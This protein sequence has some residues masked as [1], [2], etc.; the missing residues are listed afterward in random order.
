MAAQRALSTLDDAY[1]KSSGSYKNVPDWMYRDLASDYAKILVASGQISE[2]GVDKIMQ[3]SAKGAV[4]EI[5]NRLTGDTKTTAPEKV[6]TLLHDRIKALNTDLDKQYYN[7]TSGSNIP[8]NSN[9]NTNPLNNNPNAD[10]GNGNKVTQPIQ[11]GKY[12]IKKVK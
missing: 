4:V 11:V 7:Q 12:T 10:N 2:G 9:E 6:L 5:Y 8:I 3:K 1:D